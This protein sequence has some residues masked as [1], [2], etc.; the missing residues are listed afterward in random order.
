MSSPRSHPA[1]NT[2]CSRPSR[3]PSSAERIV[4]HD[5]TAARTTKRATARPSEK[6][7]MR[8]TAARVLNIRGLLWG[9]VVRREVLVG[10]LRRAGDAHERIRGLPRSP[11]IVVV[12][13]VDA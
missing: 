9:V 8:L 2:I 13:A 1:Q 11:H 4:H 3:S 12:V 7:F 10:T 5:R 6:R